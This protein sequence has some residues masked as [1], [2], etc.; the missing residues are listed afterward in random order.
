MTIERRD[1]LKVGAI[2]A[3]SL[4]NIPSA[5][6]RPERTVVSAAISATIGFGGILLTRNR[7]NFL[8]IAG[9]VFTAIEQVACATM[10]SGDSKEDALQQ[11]TTAPVDD[12]PR[13]FASLLDGIGNSPAD[14]REW[15]L[16]VALIG[17]L[18]AGERDTY[19]TFEKDSIRMIKFL[20]SAPSA[21]EVGKSNLDVRYLR[22]Q[23]PTSGINFQVHQL[24]KGGGILTLVNDGKE[25]VGFDL[26][27]KTPKTSSLTP[28]MAIF[29]TSAYVKP[30]YQQQGNFTRLRSISIR[31][32][33]ELRS[34]TDMNWNVTSRIINSKLATQLSG[35]L[36]RLGYTVAKDGIT[37]NFSA[38]PDQAAALRALPLPGEN[39][40]LGGQK[41]VT[42]KV[43][44]VPADLPARISSVVTAP[45]IPRSGGKSPA[46]AQPTLPSRLP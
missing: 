27:R 40:Q 24:E 3:V 1:L 21:T 38:T 10:P 45:P 39:S 44:S 11:P 5:I 35:T 7:N 30:E 15:T 8:P 20:N 25:V 46:N 43:E 16:Y 32:L 14:V 31:G 17:S 6:I 37:A 12:D 22:D 29:E 9:A 41:T 4:T 42:I 19:K 26:V 13:E 36:T 33:A 2:T 18:T 28:G 23:R 34:L